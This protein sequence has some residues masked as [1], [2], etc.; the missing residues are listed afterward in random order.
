M[1]K[2]ERLYSSE[3]GYYISKTYYGRI[4]CPSLKSGKQARV[5]VHCT[6]LDRYTS[7]TIKGESWQS[8]NCFGTGVASKITLQFR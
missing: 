3:L 5:R 4:S 6:G 7:W 8:G 1:R 2:S